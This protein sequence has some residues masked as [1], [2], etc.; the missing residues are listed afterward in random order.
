MNV[1]TFNHDAV[2]AAPRF[3]SVPRRPGKRWRGRSLLV[4]AAYGF[5][6]LSTVASFAFLTAG[7]EIPQDHDECENN[8]NWPEYVIYTELK[9]Q[10]PLY[11][12]DQIRCD[13]WLNHP[14][15]VKDGSLDLSASWRCY[16]VDTIPIPN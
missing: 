9:G 1:T 8:N 6:L 3:G 12:I 2:N 13:C 7:D 14:G 15:E 5:W 4:I 11:E 10:Y 16:K